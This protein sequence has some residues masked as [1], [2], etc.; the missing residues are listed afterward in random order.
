LKVEFSFFEYG[1]SHI[2]KRKIEKNNIWSKERNWILYRYIHN[3]PTIYT[4][5]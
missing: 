4:T 3:M 5:S 1:V 2:Q